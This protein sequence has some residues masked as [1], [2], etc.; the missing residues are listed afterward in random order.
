MQN[1]LS[2]G[3]ELACELRELSILVRN[4]SSENK[5]CIFTHIFDICNKDRGVLSSGF[6]QI[7]LVLCAID[8]SSSCSYYFLRSIGFCWF[9]VEVDF[10]HVL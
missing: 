4:C 7:H 1:W 9:K 6:P 5:L 2:L 8:L 3:Q 10:C